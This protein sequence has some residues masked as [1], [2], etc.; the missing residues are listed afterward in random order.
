MNTGTILSVLAALVL[1]ATTTARTQNLSL[2]HRSSLEL[3]IGFWSGGASNTITAGGVRA[4]VGASA[5][6]GGLQFAH[7]LREYLSITVSAGLLAGKASSTVNFLN[8]TQQVSSVV[9]VLLGVKYYAL[10]SAA[11]GQVRPYL[12]AAVG[13][14][15]GSEE[16]NTLLSQESRIETAFGGRL[17]AG[18]DFFL[19]NHLKLGANADYNLMSNFSTPIGAR[20]NYNGGDFAL[21]VG[22][23]F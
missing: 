4:D 3:N 19:S 18:I 21:G 12:S 22:Y 7:S 20:R 15:V 2:A 9:P 16:S 8:V 11:D 1:V 13:P 23:I 17:G 14:Y 10:E 6:V 5:F